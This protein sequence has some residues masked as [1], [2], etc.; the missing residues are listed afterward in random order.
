MSGPAVERRASPVALR[1]EAIQS[2]GGMRAR[3]VADLV[4][5]T[6]QTIT[7]WKHGRV[8]PRPT[9]LTRLLTLEWLVSQLADLYE[10]QEAHL[11]LRAPHRLLGGDR[12]WD[13]IQSD[14]TD[15]VLALVDQLKSAAYV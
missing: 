5:T 3:E 13:R 8:E 10:P 2:K 7:R 4:G 9:H 15:D 6:E 1:L 12:P 11:W 14:Q